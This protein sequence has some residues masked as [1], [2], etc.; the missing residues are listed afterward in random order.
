M[1]QEAKNVA[2]GA[3]SGDEKVKFYKYDCPY[4]INAVI[5]VK[6]DFENLKGVLEFILQRLQKQDK[7]MNALDQKLVS[8]LMQVDK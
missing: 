6:I 7:N 2:E 5:D 8:R 3:A 1:S 4:D